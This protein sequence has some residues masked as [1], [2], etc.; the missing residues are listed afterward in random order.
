MSAEIALPAVARATPPLLNE[1]LT[2][3]V[4]PEAEAVNCLFVPASEHCTLL[5]LAT[6]LPAA[7]PMSKAAVPSSEPEPEVR[8]SVRFKLAGNPT[9]ARLPNASCDLSTGCVTSGDPTR[10]APPGWV[11]NTRRSAEFGLTAM[12]PE[13][14]LVEPVPVKLS[15][16]V[17]ATL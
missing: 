14:A 17:S 11:V 13:I 16:M 2:R 9:V 12:L 1:L 10:E 6:P 15:V 3:L 4:K 8:A 7:V 5:K